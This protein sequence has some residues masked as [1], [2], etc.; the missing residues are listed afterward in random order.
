MTI[1]RKG[2]FLE[3]YDLEGHLS[4]GIE[5]RM[6]A[7]CVAEAN[8]RRAYG[9]FGSGSFNFREDK[10]DFLAELPQLRKVFF[11]SRTSLSKTSTAST[12]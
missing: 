10:L 3:D 6:L 9:V 2:R 7:A 11:F 4:I 1:E 12:P 8:R 5:S